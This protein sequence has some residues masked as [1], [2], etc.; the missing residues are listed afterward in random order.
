MTNR[1]PQNPTLPTSGMR[2]FLDTADTTTWD[3]LLPT[4]VFYGVTTNPLLLERAQLPCTMEQ[5]LKMTHKAVVLGMKEIH[6][7]TWGENP[8]QMVERGLQLSEMSEAGI[9]VMIKVPATIDGWA[10]ATQLRDKGLSIT[11]TAVYNPSQILLASGFGAAYVAPY[12]GRMNDLGRDG[13]ADILAMHNILKRTGSFTR[14]LVASLRCS[15]EVL[16]LAQQG[17][18][19]FTFGAAVAR[20]LF[21]EDATDQAA[22]DFQRAARGQRASYISASYLNCP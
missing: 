19:T 7:Q 12:L 20:E 2:L 10:A 6:L 4:G 13:N 8:A 16:D 15:T 14:L 18:D 22:N 17:L 3:E 21:L 5:L 9:N 11:M 1:H